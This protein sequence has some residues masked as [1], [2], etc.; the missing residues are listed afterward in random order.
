MLANYA[1]AQSCVEGP[2]K[3]SKGEET[4]KIHGSDYTK[5]CWEETYNLNCDAH[6][7]ND[8]DK[9]PSDICDHIEDECLGYNQADNY[10]VCIN[11]K[12]KFSCEKQVQ[13]EDTEVK[14][15]KNNQP[16]NNKELLCASMCLDGNCKDIRKADPESSDEFEHAVGVLNAIPEIKKGINGDFIINIFKGFERKCKKRPIDF[17]NCCKTKPRGWGNTVKLKKCSQDELQTSMLRSKKQCIKVGNYTKKKWGLKTKIESFCCFD[18]VISRIIN[19][20]AKRQLGKNFGSPEYPD[21]SGISIEELARVDLSKANFADFYNEVLV[22]Q[23]KVPN[24][25]DDKKNIEANLTGIQS[26]EGSA[27]KLKNLN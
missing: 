13:Y 15:E 6:S 2:R 9:I 1:S 10:K 19:E 27:Q 23:I 16:V 24:I 14:L 5:E 25:G 22:H 3:C 18:S 17:L 26:P 8:C 20:E 11:H 7:K 4:R 21:C 12:R